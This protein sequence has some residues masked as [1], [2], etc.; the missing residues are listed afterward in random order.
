M[1]SIGELAR[2]TGISVRSI[3]HYDRHGLLCSTRACNG[4]RYF[5]PQALGQVRQIQQ[6]IATG[7]SIAE[8]AAFPACMRNEE[9]ATMCSQTRAL[10]RKRLATIEA[11][12]ATLE[13][14][15]AQLVA[16]L[17]ATEQKTTP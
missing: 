9:G 6:L 5:P 13:R 16:A 17:G 8:I 11:Q 14:R 7:F 1:F 15:R 12:I 10:Q 2:Q 3:R 4:Y